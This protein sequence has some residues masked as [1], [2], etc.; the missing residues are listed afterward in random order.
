LNIS[1]DPR[2]LEEY[3]QDAGFLRRVPRAVIHATGGEEVVRLIEDAQKRGVG[4]TPRGAGTSIPS[5]A[6][7]DGF[8]LLLDGRKVTLHGRTFESDPGVVKYDLNSLVDGS[9]RWH[10]VDP[11][12][13][14]SC[15]IGG[16]VS[17]NSS[18]VRTYKYGSTVDYV[19]EVLAVIPSV[20][21]RSLAKESVDEALAE[22]GPL[23]T[24]A[25]LIVE[26]KKDIEREVPP[27]KKNS[28]GYRL[29]RVIQGDTF[30]WAKLFVGS[31]GTLGVIE[32]VT[33]STIQ[34]PSRRVLLVAEVR[35][36]DELDGL[37][38]AMRNHGPSA[39]ELVD[40]S[41][42]KRAGKENLLRAIAR[43]DDGYIVYCEGDASTEAG[44][45]EF[46]LKLGADRRVSRYD[47]LA[48]TDEGEMREA[49]DVRNQTLTIAGELRVGKRIP[50]PGVEDLVVPEESLGRILKFVL[51]L[52]DSK[53]LDYISYGHAGDANLHL[54]PLLDP[55]DPRDLTLLRDM[56][57]DCFEMAW[58]L[59]GSMTGEHG[60][61]LLRAP[62]LARQYPRTFELMREIKRTL[63]PKGV[64]NPGVKIPSESRVP[65][66]W[67]P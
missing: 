37:V 56:M 16:M 55:G 15:T 3:S 2:E 49:W 7:G 61:G 5:Q 66:A 32:R 47:P 43:S 67:P 4:I 63:D 20:G 23:G 21:E 10:P 48:M 35:G 58:S 52:F 57:T 60:D 22:P 17:N 59:H 46:L 45:E 41:I 40:K 8:V 38:G 44:A 51:D 39:I 64:M 62:F 26:N 12:S 29:E 34:R 50:L 18:G 6:I 53:G 27:T 33:C 14:K 36:L 31:E 25:K 1:S 19:D 28:S 54:R 24:V 13:F 65:G 42:F 9:G 30:D 11:S